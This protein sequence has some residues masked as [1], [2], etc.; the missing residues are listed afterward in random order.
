MKR[1]GPRPRSIGVLVAV[2]L[3]TGCSTEARQKWLPFFFDGVP[4]AG[5]PEPPPTRKVRQDLQ[6]EVEA[7]R[8]ENADLRAAA[9]ARAEGARP[10]EPERP[11]ER[12]R[13]WAEA[14]A[15][16]P[17][18]AG[19]AV[20]WG[21]A[22]DTGVIQPRSGLDPGAPTQPAFDMDVKLARGRHPFFAAGFRHASHTRLLACASCHPSPFPVSAG[23]RRPVITMAAIREGQSCGTCHGPVAFGVETRCP[24]CHTT[25]PVTDPWRPPAPAAPLESLHSWK[26]VAARLP[27]K[28]DE[29]DWSTALDKGLLA[30]K[31]LPGQAEIVTLEV[32]VERVPNEGGEAMKAVFPHKAHTALLACDTCHPTLY[33]FKAGATPITMAQLEKG[34]SCGVC[35]GKVAFPVT[36]CGRCHPAL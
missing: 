31:S 11:A 26:E 2:L 32:D 8:R 23:T 1:P 7:L 29:P 24:A 14:E 22:I 12:A 33:Q 18:D 4:D 9:Q 34:E 28:A 27:V 15:L 5:R 30:P 16:L 36:A 10:G 13:T 17:H 35:H 20:D 19:G 3:V 25:I 21:R 6:R